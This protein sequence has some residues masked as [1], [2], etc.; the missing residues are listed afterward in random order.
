MYYRY[1]RIKD[2]FKELFFVEMK[3]ILKRLLVMKDMM[4]SIL[5]YIL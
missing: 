3:M 1:E 2:E 5:A 4:S